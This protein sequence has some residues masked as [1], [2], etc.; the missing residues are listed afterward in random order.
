MPHV[1][2]I[3]V[4]VGATLLIAACAANQNP[5]RPARGGANLI[6]NPC[7]SGAA[8]STKQEPIVC[9]DDSARKL[10]AS[11]DPVEVHDVKAGDPSTPVE[12]KW[13]TTSGTGDVQV[14]IEPGCVTDQSCDGHGK[15][16]AKAV[17][18]G[19]S[20]CKYDVWIAGDDKHDRL[21][22]TVVVTGCCT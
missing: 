5:D 9:I 20:R 21:D 19:K 12:V 11:P 15:C 2:R 14:A 1:L 13:F 16:K 3:P 10:V 17:K 7:T 18:G 22:P 8:V 4:F 6:A